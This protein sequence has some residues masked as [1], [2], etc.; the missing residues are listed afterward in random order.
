MCQNNANKYRMSSGFPFPVPWKKIPENIY[1]NV[2]F[3][4]SVLRMPDVVA[5]RKALR[6]KGLK[7]PINFFGM[8]R[9]DVPWVTVTAEGASIPVDY[10][11][12]NVTL[13]NPIVLSVAPAVEQDPELV[14]WL[15]KRPTALINLGSTVK[16][17]IL[18]NI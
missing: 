3:I 15:K 12:S 14:D 10:L 11:P 9:D 16:V 18:N 5:K 13:T 8:Y 17:S 2:R 4:Y 6:E 7:D 1:L